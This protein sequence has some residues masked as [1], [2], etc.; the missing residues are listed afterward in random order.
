[1][2][3]HAKLSA[4]GSERW[5]NC[6][7]SVKLSE[8]L[9]PTPDSKYAIEGT[10]AHKLYEQWLNHVI[11]K[12]AFAFRSPGAYP[13]GMVETVKIGIDAIKKVWD[14]G[15]TGKLETEKRVSL[16]FIDEGMFGTLDTR[17]I[18]HFGSLYIFDY[19]HGAG[20][21]V[22]VQD[23]SDPSRFNHNTQL[24][25][26]AL[27]SAHEF[28]YDFENVVLGIIQPRA[29]HHQGPIRS[30]TLPI[31]LLQYYEGIFKRGVEQTKKKDPKFKAGKWC[32]WCPGTMI[33]NKTK[34]PHCREYTKI[35]N[36]AA[37]LAFSGIE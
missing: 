15:R 1:M 8:S 11:T 34:R 32:K 18:E 10:K 37:A 14:N 13:K 4:S 28:D 3:A 33:D 17:I 5:L 30:A 26:Y 12:S 6:P 36:S 19:K 7:A 29:L 23:E 21:A 16:E 24:I 9:P 20:I 22:D 27:A 25:Y 31:R 35:Q 2:K